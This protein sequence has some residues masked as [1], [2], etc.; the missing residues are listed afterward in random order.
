[1]SVRPGLCTC[2]VGGGLA[3]AL[4]AGA[5]G[6]AGGQQQARPVSTDASL[7]RAVAQAAP[8]TGPRPGGAPGPLGV[9]AGV[10]SPPAVLLAGT[11]WTH[12]T[13]AERQAYVSGF[14]AGA[15]AEQVRGEAVVAH[16]AGD[17]AA[18]SSAAVDSLHAVHALRFRFAPAVYASQ[19]DDF[20]WWENHRR[21]PIVDAM[22][23]INAQ[24]DGQQDHGGP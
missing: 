8:D 10:D 12:L 6:I 19:M 7:S 11:Y 24:L 2:G 21:I 16:R 3:L 23:V 14:L 4:V 20:Y 15:A 13:E 1:M 9:G 17:S 5:A 22:I 18:V